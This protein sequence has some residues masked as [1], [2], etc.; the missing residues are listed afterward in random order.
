VTCTRKKFKLGSLLKKKVN[1]RAL[2]AM[3]VAKP[4]IIKENTIA[5]PE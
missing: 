2:P 5:G 1:P 4:D 3:Q